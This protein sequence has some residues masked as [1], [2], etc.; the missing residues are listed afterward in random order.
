MAQIYPLPEHSYQ[1]SQ[2]LMNIP[3]M[4][5]T[6]AENLGGVISDKETVA[7]LARRRVIK[8]CC[9]VCGATAQDKNLKR[10]GKC[11][12]VQYCSRE[13]QVK[14]WENGGH[15]QL[16]KQLRKQQKKKKDEQ[17][18]KED[19]EVTEQLKVAEKS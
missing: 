14:D 11:R 10:C 15:K 8:K 12:S 18:K 9:A 19:K 5:F 13:H 7:L 4:G 16:C 2:E 3:G 6:T 1:F 17:Q